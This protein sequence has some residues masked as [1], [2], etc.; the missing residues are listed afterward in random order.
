MQP[1]VQVHI[2]ETLRLFPSRSRVPVLLESGPSFTA[3][4]VP[5]PLQI[6][7]LLAK[8]PSRYS[9]ILLESG[10]GK[11]APAR[12]ARRL[13]DMGGREWFIETLLV[14][15]HFIIVMIRW[16]GLAPMTG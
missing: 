15:I 7:V 5:V 4:Q 11:A 14:Q 3:G 13:R 1:R 2:F 10:P 9:Y 16:T 6:Y 12:E 8:Y